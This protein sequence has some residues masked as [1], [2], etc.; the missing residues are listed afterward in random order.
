MEIFLFSI[1]F[2]TNVTQYKNLYRHVINSDS[3][4]P[5]VSFFRN[6]SNNLL[7]SS[8]KI[9]IDYHCLLTDKLYGI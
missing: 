3:V 8:S 4:T 9:D 2:C 7:S 5:Y 1:L 6:K